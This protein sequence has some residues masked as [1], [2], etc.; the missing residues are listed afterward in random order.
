MA[1]ERDF[2][3]LCEFDTLKQELTSYELAVVDLVYSE[4][5]GKT[6]EEMMAIVDNS[7]RLQ[8]IEHIETKYPVLRAVSSMKFGQLEKELQDNVREKLKISQE[9][10]A[11]RV[12]EQHL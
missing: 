3:S 2:E 5:P 7:I 6:V 4:Y 8:W 9:I 1:L 12:K 11:L 10:L